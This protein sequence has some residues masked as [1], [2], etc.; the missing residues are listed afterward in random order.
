MGM[1]TAMDTKEQKKITW[2]NFLHLYQPPSQSKEVIDLVVRESYSLI[3]NLLNAYPTLK[4]TVNMS[5]SLLE[6][7]EQHGYKNVIEGFVKYVKEGRVELVGSAMYHPIIPLITEEEARRQIVLDNEINKK[8]FGDAYKPKGFYFPEM[9]VDVKS[10]KLVKEMGFEWVIL[11]E[12]H[13]KEK[14]SADIKYIEKQSGINVVF[15]NS[16]FSR[17][18]PPEFIIA[19][20][21]KIS[22][23]FLVTAHDAELY[24]HWHKD[25]RGHYEKIHTSPKF[26]TVTVSD[27]VS[28]L[29]ETK[30]IEIREASWES[31]EEELKKKNTLSLWNSAENQVHQALWKLSETATAILQ[32]HQ[33]DPHIGN[34]SH[35]LSKGMASCAWWWASER[36]LGPF[37]P[38]TW[39]PTE[40]EKGAHFMLNSVRS[41]K[42]IKKSERTQAEKEFTALHDLVWDRHWTLNSQDL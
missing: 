37:S 10:L 34:A 31:T 39:N 25:D 30:E 21:S 3:L 41:L 42:K 27:Y 16:L 26:D 11:D 2:V 8:Y 33:D 40:I 19:N 4:F 5:G 6:L 13:T 23:Q 24:G 38:L 15:R 22:T 35:A 7:L 12:I 18:F 20:A 36:K 17:S 29:T 1:V 9:A 28:K 32:A 14:T